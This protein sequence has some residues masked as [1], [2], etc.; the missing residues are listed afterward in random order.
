MEE[1]SVY[2]LSRRDIQQAHEYKANK[3]VIYY[4][5]SYK[6]V[7]VKYILLDALYRNID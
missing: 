1:R 4:V 3:F 7:I 6:N 2:E 5:K